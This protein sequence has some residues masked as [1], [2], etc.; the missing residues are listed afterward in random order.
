MFRSPLTK[1]RKLTIDVSTSGSNEWFI[2]VTGSPP[3]ARMSWGN[4][5]KTGADQ[6]QGFHDLTQDCFVPGATVEHSFGYKS[7]S[8]DVI[9]NAT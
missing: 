9:T 3:N 1:V 6:N 7:V 4:K 5:K 8:F 2:F